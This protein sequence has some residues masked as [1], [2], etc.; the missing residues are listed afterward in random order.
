MAVPRKAISQ[1]IFTGHCSG[2][3]FEGLHRETRS[4]ISRSDE[5]KALSNLQRSV[6]R[7]RTL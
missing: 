7:S 5:V 4:R 6:R 2:L 1:K 3:I